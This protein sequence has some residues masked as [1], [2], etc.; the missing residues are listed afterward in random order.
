MKRISKVFFSMTT[1]GLLLVVFAVVIALATFVENDYGT[2]AAR[3]LVYNAWWFEVLLLLLAMNLTGSILVNKLL[4]RQ[5]WPVA[6]FHL[7]FVIILAGAAIT[8]YTGFEGT[9]HIRE[10]KQNNKILSRNGFIHI[11]GTQGEAKGNLTKQVNFTRGGKNR[12]NGTLE[13]GNEKVK[14]KTIRFVPSAVESPYDAPDGEPIV[15]ILAIDEMNK[16][17]EFNLKQNTEQPVGDVVFRFGGDADTNVLH[18]TDRG[19]MLFFSFPDT[20]T[21]LIMGEEEETEAFAPGKSYPFAERAIFQVGDVGFVLKKFFPSAKIELVP[22]PMQ[23]QGAHRDAVQ[24]WISSGNAEKEV[25]LYGRAGVAGTPVNAEINGINLKMQYG[26]LIHHLPFTLYLEDFQLERYPGSNS[27]SSFASEV[28]LYDPENNLEKPYRIFMN[29]I[30]KYGG[31]RFFQSNYDQDELGTILS[32]NYDAPGTV[33]TY[34]GYFLM[35]LGMVL[36]FFFRRSR[37]RKLDSLLSTLSRS[38]KGT[39]TAI[40]LIMLMTAGIPSGAAEPLKQVSPTH[41][42]NFGRMQVQNVDGRIEP[43]NT[44]ASELLR[45]IA[46]KSSYEGLNPVQVMLGMMLEPERW[47]EEKIIRVSSNDIAKSIGTT[48]KYASF[49]DFLDQGQPNGYK[50]ST[51]VQAAYDKPPGQRTKFDKEIINVD[52]RVNILYK[53]LSGGFL[54]IFPIPES[55]DNKWVALA[56]AHQDADRNMAVF[57]MQSMQEYLGGLEQGLETGDYSAADAALEKISDNQRAHGAALYPPSFKTTLE[58]FYIDFNLFSKLAKVYIIVGLFLLVIQ[59]IVLLS[60]G[61]PMKRVTQAGFW[62]V[63]LLFLIHTGGLAIRWYISGHAPWSNGYE[64]LLYISWASLLAGLV[65]AGR[66]PM[67]LAVTTIQ[68]A[69]SL[70]V[71]G[72]SWMNPE[73]TNLVP[74]LKSIWLIIHVAVITASYGFLGMGAL[75]G[76]VNLVLMILKNS[77]NT[78]K[79][80]LSIRELTYITEMALILGLYMLTIGSFLGGVWANESWG[81]YWGWDPKETWAMVTILVYAFIT[82]MHRI[83]GLRGEF[84]FSTASLLGFSSVLMTFFGVNY[85]LSGLHSYAQGDP[86][87]IPSGVYIALVV[88][89]ILITTAWMAERQS[90]KLKTK[91]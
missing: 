6:F 67:T 84:A 72:M 90:E 26:S 77:S 9:L 42:K 89:A 24:L 22:D 25:I 65:F 58:I 61:E 8:R 41:A 44:L 63:M 19:G 75:L 51:Y 1:T 38:R 87:P 43:V 76:M 17:V 50:L 3:L 49:T 36:T 53:M 80:S 71:A 35:T 21:M 83:P 13:V 56:T 2:A 91:S 78:I 79:I 47:Q 46:K 27:P 18:I 31:Y 45:K 33:V 86:P 59:F 73:L 48:G 81:R 66:S 12:F 14:V 62:L 70:F 82:H 74:V 32:V 7:S 57:A 68:A 69:I 23:Q 29:N 28:V 40:I 88:V 10:G 16:R 85:Y 30:L 64:T 11:E 15:S 20:I 34:I 4:T 55:P 60:S 39:I 5:K 52:E 37:F 54:T